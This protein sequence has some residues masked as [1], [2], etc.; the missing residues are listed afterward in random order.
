MNGRHWK[1]RV[2]K[3]PFHQACDPG[4]K[5]TGEKLSAQRETTKHGGDAGPENTATAVVTCSHLQASRIVQDPEVEPV[6]FRSLGPN[7]HLW[8]VASEGAD[9]EVKVKP[10][11]TG[12]H[13]QQKC[14]FV[15]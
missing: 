10:S 2:F 14:G 15:A 7:P 11:K 5:S 9:D 3:S 8:K 13:T 4:Q 6:G 1:S 12:A